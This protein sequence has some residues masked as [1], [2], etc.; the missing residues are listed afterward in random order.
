[1]S[2]VFFTAL[3]SAIHN[4]RYLRH[5]LIDAI[6]ARI[7]KTSNLRGKKTGCPI[8]TTGIMRNGLNAAQNKY[9]EFQNNPFEKAFPHLFKGLTTGANNLIV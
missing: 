4:G 8:G 2:V 1:V 7:A 9:V 5:T 6:V 3:S